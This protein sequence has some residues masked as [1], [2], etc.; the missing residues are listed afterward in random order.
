MVMLPPFKTRQPGRWTDRLIQEGF[1]LHMGSHGFT[2]HVCNPYPSKLTDKA[3]SHQ[4]A[5]D[6]NTCQKPGPGKPL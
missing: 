6:T 4:S 5:D 3:V 2:W 1:A